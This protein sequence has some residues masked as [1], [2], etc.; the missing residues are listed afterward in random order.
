MPRPIAAIFDMDGVLIDSY[1]THFQSWRTVLAAHNVPFTESQF[2]QVFG[3]TS[4]ESIQRIWPHELPSDSEIAQLDAAKEAEFRR[5]V[6]DRFPIMEGAAELITSL[7][8]S[9]FAIA[10]ASSGPPENVALAVEKLGAHLFDAVVTGAD[11][12]RGKPDPEVFLRAAKK[13]NIVPDRC[14]VFEDAPVGIAA[15]R[16][17]E[18]ACIGLVSTGRTDEQ[19]AQADLV[20]HHL[21][22]L[23]P[24]RVQ[25]LIRP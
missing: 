15:A 12:K 10:I 8:S 16:S 14:V 4:R 24:E 20:V 13:L 11:V 21:G 7:R 5:L 18:M 23:S 17:A 19:L 3:R 22:D 25:S 6:R 2:A 9:G 1:E